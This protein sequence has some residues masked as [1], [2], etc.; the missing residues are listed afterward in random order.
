MPQDNPHWE[1]IA[2][3]IRYSNNFHGITG[4]APVLSIS[5]RNSITEGGRAHFRIVVNPA[6]TSPITV[7]IG[8]SETGDWGARA[9]PPRS[10]STAATWTTTRP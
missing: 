9:A 1:G 10:H 6:P 5:S 8:V 2:E 7:N 3:A 4:P